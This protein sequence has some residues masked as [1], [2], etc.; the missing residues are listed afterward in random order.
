MTDVEPRMATYSLLLQ[1][2]NGR[3]PTGSTN[4]DHVEVASGKGHDTII[5]TRNSA[6]DFSVKLSPCMCSHTDSSCPGC[7]HM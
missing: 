7:W 2:I 3:L 1:I 6:H 5:N 4:F